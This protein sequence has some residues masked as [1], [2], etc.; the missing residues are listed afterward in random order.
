[1]FRLRIS[2]KWFLLGTTLTAVLIGTVGKRSY[3]DWQRRRWLAGQQ[4]L[5]EALIA[6]K[7]GAEMRDGCVF[8]VYL[9]AVNGL[10]DKSCL[11]DATATEY[12]VAE[13]PLTDREIDFL[14]GAANLR[15]LRVTGDR[16]SD[17]ALRVIGRCSELEGLVI[18]ESAITDAGLVHLGA[19]KK[20]LTCDLA[21]SQVRGWGLRHI[22]GN[23]D[24]QIL[25][26]SG[27]PV[28]DNGLAAIGSCKQLIRL[29]LSG[30]RVTG[31]GLSQLAGLSKLNTLDLSR[32][33]LVSN[34]ALDQLAK[35]EALYLTG[36]QVDAGALKQVAEMESL[37]ELE[38]TGAHIPDADLALVESIR[39]AMT[40]R[41]KW[42]SRSPSVIATKVHR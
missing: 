32:T 28:D 5:R 1:M 15:A 7:C 23:S 26:L 11:K 35:V 2:L 30:T 13:C 6:A 24:L 34:N 36:A 22:A 14:S 25:S 41:A 8:T 29:D 37:L 18:T 40:N 10:K 4:S 20:L 33:T 27:C 38:L 3:D 17:R 21:R 12:F 39:E 42:K 9:P 31:R 16:I 19:L